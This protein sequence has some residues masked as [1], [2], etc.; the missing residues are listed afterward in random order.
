MTVSVIIPTL[1]EAEYVE[2]TLSAVARQPGPK[3]IIVVDGGSTDGTVRRAAPYARVFEAPRGRAVQMNHGAEAA[4]GD[5]FFFLH[6]DTLPPPEGL[7]RIRGALSRPGVVAGTFR[8]AFDRPS[9]LLQLYSWCTRWPW[10]RLAF[11][12]RGLFVRR[13]TFEIVDGFPRW[14]IFEDLELAA[15][16]HARGTFRFLPQAVTTSAR[17]FEA[18]GP[19]RQQLRNLELWMHYVAGRDPE[20]VAHR[21]PYGEKA[22][23]EMGVAGDACSDLC[24]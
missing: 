16:L 3:E 2:R 21:Y 8:L 10:I 20:E 18:H 4:S 22:S 23:S 13:R 5:A 1:N 17:R 6:A 24:N 15:R 11:G 9:P 7:S 12:D 14:P 19:F